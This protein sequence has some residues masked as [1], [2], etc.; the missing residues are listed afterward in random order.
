MSAHD[1]L[2]LSQNGSFLASL[3]TPSRRRKSDSERVGVLLPD[4]AELVTGRRA[5]LDAAEV[6]DSVVRH[7]RTK[8]EAVPAR[9]VP[10]GA[11]RDQLVAAGFIEAMK[12]DSL[13]S[14][15]Y[16]PAD[17]LRK[18]SAQQAQKADQPDYPNMSPRSQPDLGVMPTDF[19][20]SAFGARRY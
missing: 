10:S 3:P 19:F 9:V 5:T 8:G 16:R 11:V 2:S 18:A 13:G 12:T 4:V 14:T 20:R 17:F 6:L 15:G 7:Y 1:K